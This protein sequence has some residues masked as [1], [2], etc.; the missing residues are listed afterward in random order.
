MPPSFTCSLF[1]VVLIAILLSSTFTDRVDSSPKLIDAPVVLNPEP[2][3]TLRELFASLPFSI[4]VP[5]IIAFVMSP[6]EPVVIIVPLLLGIII[7][8]S[9]D[10]SITSRVVS[11]SSAVAPSKIIVPSV[12]A[13]VTLLN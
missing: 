11:Y 3:A 13:S 1:E 12:P 7:V 6:V 2:A 9:S 4:V 5:A 8:L 10:G